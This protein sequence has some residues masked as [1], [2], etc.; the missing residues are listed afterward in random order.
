LAVRVA[1]CACFG[2]DALAEVT[3]K[4]QLKPLARRTNAVVLI[5]GLDPGKMFM[6]VQRTKAAASS[7]T[8]KLSVTIFQ[9]LD[10]WNGYR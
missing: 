7:P 10:R 4:L 3:S 1:G 8:G 2:A 5:R 6:T 9:G